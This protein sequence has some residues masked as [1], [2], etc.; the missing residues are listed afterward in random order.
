MQTISSVKIFRI[1]RFFVIMKKYKRN[2]ILLKEVA[3]RLKQLR[4][5]KGLSQADVYIDTDLNMSRVEGGRT[6]I[7]LTTLTALCKYYG[8]TLEELFRG[9]KTE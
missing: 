3:K 2:D 1:F 9:I 5:A 4:E 6:S 7:T 8:T